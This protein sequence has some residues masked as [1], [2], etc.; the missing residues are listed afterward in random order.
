MKHY[1]EISDEQIEILRCYPHPWSFLGRRHPS[2]LL[3]DWMDE[4]QYHM[5]SIRIARICIPDF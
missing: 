3:P 2:F 4:D 1:I 5:L